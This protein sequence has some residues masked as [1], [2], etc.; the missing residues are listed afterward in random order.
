MKKLTSL[1]IKTYMICSTVCV[2]PLALAAFNEIFRPKT[3]I[4]PMD[5]GPA[6]IITAIGCI[7]CMLE[8][9]LKKHEANEIIEIK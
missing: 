3:T 8:S 5:F 2:A 7:N 1:A 9:Y 6:L 4:H